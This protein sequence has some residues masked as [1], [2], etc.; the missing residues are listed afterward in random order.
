[1]RPIYSNYT[2]NCDWVEGESVIGVSLTYA[3]FRTI[4]A[5]WDCA[6]SSRGFNLIETLKNVIQK[7]LDDFKALL[8]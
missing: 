5:R 1:L 8:K 6:S 7:S 4:D 2:R 3:I